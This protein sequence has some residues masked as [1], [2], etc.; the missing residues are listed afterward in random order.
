ME[1]FS[2]RWLTEG[3]RAKDLLQGI[4]VEDQ[5]SNEAEANMAYLKLDYT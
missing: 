5:V 3:S 2:N 1:P 4:L